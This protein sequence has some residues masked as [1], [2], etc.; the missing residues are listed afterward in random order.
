MAYNPYSAA[1]RI[2]GYKNEWDNS[3]EET[4]KRVAQKAAQYYGELEQN[5]YSKLAEQLRNSNTSGARDI[6]ARLGTSG[7]TP[8]RK[9]ITD[10][11]TGQYGMSADAANQAL[12]YNDYNG[13]ILL[14]GIN[15]GKGDAF[16]DNTNYVSDT[17]RLDNAIKQFAESTGRVQ[18]PQAQISQANQATQDKIDKAWGINVAKDGTS[19]GYWGDYM[20]YVKANPFTSPEEKSILNRYSELGEKA[21]YGAIAN[22]AGSNGGNIDSYA[23]A[24][25][26]RQLASF[27]NQGQEAALNYYQ[28]KADQFLAGASGYDQSRAT[29]ADILNQNIGQQ[30]DY[31]QRLFDNNETAQNNETDRLATQASISGYNPEQWVN[32]NNPFFNKETGELLNPDQDFEENYVI[33][34]LKTMNDSNATAL[35]KASAQQLYNWAQ[36]A[37]LYKVNN[38]DQYKQYASTVRGYTPSETAEVRM[39]RENNTTEQAISENATKAAT[40]QL[41]KQLE[42]DKYSVNKNYD[43]EKYKTDAEERVATMNAINEY[44]NGLVTASADAYEKNALSR[45]ERNKLLASIQEAIAANKTDEELANIIEREELNPDDKEWLYDQSGI[46]TLQDI[47]CRKMANEGRT[48]E[49]IA[50]Y[51]QSQYDG[52][53]ISW[54]RAQELANKWERQIENGNTGNGKKQSTRWLL[55]D[56]AVK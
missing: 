11:L 25:A 32:S 21:G 19:D 26:A 17:K 13:D 23:Q 5:G 9:Y 14:G 42:A 4:R 44:N 54:G 24:Q 37:K 2:L 35:E 38:Y 6:I 29:T 34:A 22:G 47:E 56:E 33:P 55:T 30:S 8:V 48:A 7:K 18:L 43:L 15:I 51:L 53:H 52:G 39:N 16:A 28:T 45:D 1:N 40:D 46:S 41:D 50:M 12:T 10:A 20:N 27:E 31:A 49:E 36:A 3:D